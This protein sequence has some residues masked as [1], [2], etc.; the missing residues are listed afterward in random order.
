MHLF[1]NLSVKHKVMAITL[2]AIVLSS[3]LSSIAYFA[4]EVERARHAMIKELRTISEIV[5]D[6]SAA[7]LVFN[8]PAAAT[9]T[10]SSLKT[11]TDILSAA[12]FRIDGTMF[13]SFMAKAYGHRPSARQLVMERLQVLLY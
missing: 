1:H 8:D 9:E 13:A 5:A 12:I 10:L 6:N 3:L 4:I 7:A 2:F 11:K